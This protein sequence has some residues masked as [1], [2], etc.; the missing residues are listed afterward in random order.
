MIHKVNKKQ[1]EREERMEKYGKQDEEIIRF[2]IEIRDALQDINMKL[3]EMDK[4]LSRQAKKPK[5]LDKI[6][7]AMKIKIFIKEIPQRGSSEKSANL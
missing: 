7:I 2:G 4:V 1:Q 5:A 3:Q 6:I